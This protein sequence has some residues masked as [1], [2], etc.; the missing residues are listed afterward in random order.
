LVISFGNF[1]AF[2]IALGMDGF[3]VFVGAQ[4]GLQIYG[5]VTEYTGH[6]WEGA[7]SHKHTSFGGL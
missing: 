7:A 4:I 3:T 5:A 6:L 1:E 2:G